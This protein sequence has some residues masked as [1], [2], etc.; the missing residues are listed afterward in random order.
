[1]TSLRRNATTDGK[2]LLSGLQMETEDCDGE[3][4]G[5]GDDSFRICHAGHLPSYVKTT[6]QNR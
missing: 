6:L 1:V 4:T 2:P 5:S 3:G